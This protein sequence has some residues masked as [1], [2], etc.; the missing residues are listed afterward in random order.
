MYIKNTTRK[1]LL[2]KNAKPCKS[3]FS[4]TLGL[5]F[6]KSR[7]LIFIFDKEKITPLHMFF[8]FYPID[9]LF[10]NKKKGVIETK[11]D[12]RPFTFY[13][14]K[15]KALYIVELPKDTIKSSKTKIGDKIDFGK[16]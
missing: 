2:A 13:T 1:T 16:Q 5:M 8:V 7:P 10:L 12:F 3:V 11:E 15:Y 4:R 14:P 6:S 9:V